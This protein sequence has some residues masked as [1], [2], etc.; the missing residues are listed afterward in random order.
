[1]RVVSDNKSLKVSTVHGKIFKDLHV[2]EVK[3]ILECLSEQ[4]LKT[5]IGLGMLFNEVLSLLVWGFFVFQILL[6][7]EWVEDQMQIHF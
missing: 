3:A 1:M 2:A 6:S 4:I 5:W 7:R